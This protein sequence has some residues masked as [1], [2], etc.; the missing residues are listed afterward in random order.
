MWP[1]ALKSCDRCVFS[2]SLMPTSW[3]YWRRTKQK[4]L[5]ILHPFLQ[6]KTMWVNH[7]IF[8]DQF[9]HIHGALWSNLTCLLVRE[10]LFLFPFLYHMLLLHGRSC[11]IVRLFWEEVRRRWRSPLR[12]QRQGS[13][14]LG[15]TTWCSRRRLGGS[16]VTLDP[17]TASNFTQM[18]RGVCMWGSDVWIFHIE[19]IYCVTGNTTSLLASTKWYFQYTIFIM[20]TT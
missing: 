3:I 14:M 7:R 1:L 16:K 11:P 20:Y 6:L 13:L 2:S 12:T 19:V 15:S 17:S 9:P 5:S 10:A 8:F 18:G 4:G